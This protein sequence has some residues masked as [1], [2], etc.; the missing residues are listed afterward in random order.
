[1]WAHNSD[2]EHRSS[3]H[4][5]KTCCLHVSANQKKVWVKRGLFWRWV[6]FKLDSVIFIVKLYS[7]LTYR[8]LLCFLLFY[9]M[10]LLSNPSCWKVFPVTVTSPTG[11]FLVKLH[12]HF[13][14]RAFVLLKTA[15]LISQVHKLVFLF[16]TITKNTDLNLCLHHCWKCA[17]STSMYFSLLAFL[18]TFPIMHNESC[19]RWM[20]PSV[21][22]SLM[23]CCNWDV[24]RV[25]WQNFV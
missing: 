21:L 11:Q 24:W 14:S 9:L 10:S 19:N 16:W 12:L 20:R 15:S 4:F 23:L 1:M 13:I 5:K 17:C 7:A 2:C 8:L 3:T 18:R 22:D 6:H 25:M